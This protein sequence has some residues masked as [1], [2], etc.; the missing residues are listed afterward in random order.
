MAASGCR[1]VERPPRDVIARWR[2]YLFRLRPRLAGS[3]G[4]TR[5]PTA[6]L[7]DAFGKPGWQKLI[8]KPCGT[9]RAG[10]GVVFEVAA[11]ATVA[12]QVGGRC[13]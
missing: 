8:C 7:I 6:P 12:A 1:R 10:H 2:S 13:H 3:V 11:R 4:A 9:V 5:V